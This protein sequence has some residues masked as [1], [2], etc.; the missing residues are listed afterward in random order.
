MP[1]Q[2]QKQIEDGEFEKA[3]KAEQLELNKADE[4]LEKKDALDVKPKPN[5]HKKSA[6]AKNREERQTAVETQTAAAAVALVGMADAKASEMVPFSPQSFEEAWKIAHY[7]SRS[8][9]VNDGLKGN[10]GA[11]LAVMA[12]G[13]NIGVHW[14]V[15]V[16]KAHVIYGRVGWPA[17]LLAGICDRD[18]EYFEVIECDNDH[19]VVEAKM[20]RW[21][22]PR[23][24]PVTIKDAK[25]AGFLDGK[26][27]A[28]WTSRRPM[29]MLIAM[30]R[31]E[32]ARLWN[33]KLAGVLTPDEIM[34]AETPVKNV[35]P[36]VSELTAKAGNSMGDK[37]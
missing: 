10:P 29:P 37:A 8:G 30:A 6:A 9:I 31:R 13:E 34:V 18:F 14:S 27:S 24:Y 12:S 4:A 3:K 17:D 2:T 33:S 20:K 26:H 16:Q 32:A 11:V 36:G 28:L 5:G 25:D 35:T 19:A 7:V 15:A 22:E 23:R 1:T 21:S